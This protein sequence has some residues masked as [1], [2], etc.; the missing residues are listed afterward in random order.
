LAAC[1]GGVEGGE[2]IPEAKEK[3]RTGTRCGLDFQY[4]KDLRIFLP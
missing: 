3:R 4:E 1:V 2:E